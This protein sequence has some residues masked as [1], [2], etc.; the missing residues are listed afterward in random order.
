M[1]DCISALVL[2]TL[3]L[4]F[5]SMAVDRHR[6]KYFRAYKM[7]LMNVLLESQQRRLEQFCNVLF[8]MAG[9]RSLGNSSSLPAL[10]QRQCS[11]CNRHGKDKDTNS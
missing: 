3:S 7:S 11:K 2:V 10:L 5:S 8:Q 4:F 9:L 6:R 1:I